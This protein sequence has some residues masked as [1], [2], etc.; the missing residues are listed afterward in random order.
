[1]DEQVEVISHVRVVHGVRED[2]QLFIGENV[3]ITFAGALP[4]D[5]I[6][7]LSSMHWL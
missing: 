4:R 6:P 1:M 7:L 3:G 5:S 2:G